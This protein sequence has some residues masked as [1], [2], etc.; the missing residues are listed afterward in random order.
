[1]KQHRPNRVGGA[2]ILLRTFTVTQ[3]VF[4]GNI[5]WQGEHKVR[6]RERHICQDLVRKSYA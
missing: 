5:V 2:V 6:P 3:A 1:M 4:A